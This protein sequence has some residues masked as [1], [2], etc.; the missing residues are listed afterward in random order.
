LRQSGHDAI[1]SLLTNINEQDNLYT[2]IAS[3]GVTKQYG[4]I[5]DPN[6]KTS[7]STWQHENPTGIVA[8]RVN[9]GQYNTASEALAGRIGNPFSETKRGESTVQQFFE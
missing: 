6:L 1:K 7:Y 5:I 2:R 4:V 3:K 8:Y 9:F